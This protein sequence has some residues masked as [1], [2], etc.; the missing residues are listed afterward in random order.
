[1]ELKEQI[2]FN[3]KIKSCLNCKNSEFVFD[4]KL[5]FANGPNTLKCNK[6]SGVNDKINKLS[7]CKHHKEM[8]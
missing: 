8:I 7:C 6:F 4:C 1:M 3:D 5:W 2:D